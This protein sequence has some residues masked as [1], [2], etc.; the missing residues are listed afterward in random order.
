MDEP[1]ISLKLPPLTPEEQEAF[2][3]IDMTPILGTPSER[4]ELAMKTALKYMRRVRLL[5]AEVNM[6]RAE[7]KKHESVE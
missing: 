6:L 4:L 1:T 3:S 2:D 5:E 7:L